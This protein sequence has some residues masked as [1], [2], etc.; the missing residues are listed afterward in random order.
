MHPEA[1]RPSGRRPSPPHT[2]WPL[3]SRY[4]KRER[5]PRVTSW[6]VS[7]NREQFPKDEI[8]HFLQ[9]ESF[10]K[11]TSICWLLLRSWWFLRRNFSTLFWLRDPFFFQTILHTSP[12]HLSKIKTMMHGK[13]N[14]IDTLGKEPCKMFK[15]NFDP[16]SPCLCMPHWLSHF[17][18]RPPSPC[19][20]LNSD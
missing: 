20:P 7:L 6:A 13:S 18:F 12:A 3:E 10:I 17:G 19:R 15:S 16:P 9:L 11:L 1:I 14:F 4:S 8:G 5:Y 2:P